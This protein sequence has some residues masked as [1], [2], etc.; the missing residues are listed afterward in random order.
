MNKQDNKQQPKTPSLFDID[1]TKD[2]FLGNEK[3]KQTDFF[4]V[5]KLKGCVSDQNLIERNDVWVENYK[6]KSANNPS[7]MNIEDQT[8][9]KIVAFKNDGVH[10][11]FWD[12]KKQNFGHRNINST[13]SFNDEKGLFHKNNQIG[14]K[15]NIVSV[16]NPFGGI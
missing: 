9:D 12:G 11:A 15:P 1:S 16:K 5:G 4:N 6:E 10:N 3:F 13:N 8:E 2:A 14:P 7:K